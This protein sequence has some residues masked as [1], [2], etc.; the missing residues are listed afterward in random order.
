[1]HGS[2][3]DGPG[4]P[5]QDGPE[6]GTGKLNIFAL[7]RSQ[8]ELGNART[9]S[10][11]SSHGPR[12]SGRLWSGA[13]MTKRSFVAVR[14]QAELGNEET[15]KKKR[16][17]GAADR[18]RLISEEHPRKKEIS[19]MIQQ[20]WWPLVCLA[21]L[22]AGPAAAGA[23]PPVGDKE[24]LALA[25]KIDKYLQAGWD[26]AKVKP[27]PPSD[28][29]EFL[30][31]VTLHLAGRIPSVAEVRAFLRDPSPNRRVRVVEELLKGPRYVT[32]FTNVWRSWM[33]PE[34]NASFQARF[35]VPGFEV[36]LRK[37]F[38]EDV[39]YDKMV[40]E[41]LTAPVNQ[42]QAQFVYGGGGRQPN[43]AAFYIAKDIKA[44]N[45]AG[46]TSR[47]FL[48]VRLECAQCHDHP[49]ADW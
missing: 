17:K 14:S 44:E 2:P 1:R 32:H 23:D 9:R 16:N 39:P 6:E 29:A 49:F 26:A 48:G 33:L 41:L 12:R 18:C 11:A 28:D 4:G 5:S 8:A 22:A 36:W 10:S 15:R 34:A 19:R 46:A 42:Q 40:R 27:A 21:L 43:P 38:T 13:G 25:A 31:R 30:R 37:Q 20:R 3:V 47:L 35:L 24:A 7:S 45:L